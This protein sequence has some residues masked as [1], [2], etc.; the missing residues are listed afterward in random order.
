MDLG[1]PVLM[2]EPIRA[3]QVDANLAP[4]PDVAAER[5]DAS[6]WPCRHL[7]RRQ[8]LIEFS[9]PAQRLTFIPD[10][11]TGVRC[12]EAIEGRQLRG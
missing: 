7:V 8:H 1:H 6:E 2:L 12:L 9:E 4:W 10:V 3:D 11:R 5:T